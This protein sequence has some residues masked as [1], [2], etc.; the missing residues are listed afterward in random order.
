MEW[1]INSDIPLQLLPEQCT[2]DVKLIYASDVKPNLTLLRNAKVINSRVSDFTSFVKAYDCIKTV[3]LPKQQT[4]WEMLDHL[5]EEAT[6]TIIDAMVQA[7][8][9]HGARLPRLMQNFQERRMSHNNAKT[10]LSSSVDYILAIKE[11][12]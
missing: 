9:T 12:F 5:T 3:E 8:D 4:L 7:Y 6:S 11:G 10:L 2:E 1:L